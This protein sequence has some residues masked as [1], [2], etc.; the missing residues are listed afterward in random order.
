MTDCALYYGWYAGGVAGPFIEPDFRF[1]PGVARY[2]ASRPVRAPERH[3]T[4]KIVQKIQEQNYLNT[5]TCLSPEIAA[6][7]ALPIPEV[8]CRP[9]PSP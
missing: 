4:P 2:S 6:P 3:C 7:G 5:Y 8:S 9:F 1:V